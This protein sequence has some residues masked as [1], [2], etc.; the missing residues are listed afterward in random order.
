MASTPEDRLTIT[1]EDRDRLTP[2]VDI[3]LRSS[4]K[5]SPAFFDLFAAA[6]DHITAGIREFRYITPGLL[7]GADSAVTSDNPSARARAIVLLGAASCAVHP[8][9]SG[10]ELAGRAVDTLCRALDLE[11]SKRLRMLVA[12]ELR[13]QQR[14]KLRPET[15]AKIMEVMLGALA[16]PNRVLRQRA[17][18]TFLDPAIATRDLLDAPRAA[19]ILKALDTALA[20]ESDGSLQLT[21]QQA[22]AHISTLDTR[23]NAQD[24]FKI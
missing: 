13:N 12:H 17:M 2:L 15:R 5:K 1:Q 3:F 21:L 24:A 19:E 22:R 23:P 20:R 7:D 14:T 18:M 11:P 16:D 10:R 4:A 9:P 6:A 8:E